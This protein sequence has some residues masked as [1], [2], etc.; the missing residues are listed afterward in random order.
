M[1]NTPLKGKVPTRN[2]VKSASLP[3]PIQGLNTRDPFEN[4]DPTYAVSV[5][6][7]IAT[8]QGLSVRQG[9]TSNVTGITG[10]V[11]SLLVYKGN[12]TA[13]DRLFACA[14]TQMY[15][16]TLASSTPAVVQA[17]LTS[18]LWEH[19]NATTN[20]G[21]Y[22]VA[23]NGVDP[24]R[25]YDGTTWTNFS[26]NATP[27]VPGQITTGSM[28]SLTNWKLP[29]IHQRR[30][31]ITQKNSTVA[32]YLPVDSMGGVATSFDF[33]PTFSRGGSIATMQSWSVDIG[34]GIQQ[35]LVVVSTSG[36]VVIYTGNNP[37]VATSWALAG[38]WRLGEPIGIR[39]LYPYQSDLLYL[40]QD[41]CMELSKYLK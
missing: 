8:P 25:F 1:A 17:G 30:I 28:T 12:T 7:F 38:S 22:M 2:S 10:Y 32:Y 39:C 16:A 9:Y 18:S 27:S 33:G 3:A 37:A 41:G 40:S 11:Q 26:F 13:S 20:G 4:M 36:D 34:I 19:T 21:R 6:N 35:Y 23:C 24:A 29:I 15:D 14:G 5:S 31:W